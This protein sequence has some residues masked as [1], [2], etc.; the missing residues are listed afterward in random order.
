M[1][2][3]HLKILRAAKAGALP[4]NVDKTTSGFSAEAMRELREAGLIESSFFQSSDGGPEFIDGR[5]TLAG[6]ERLEAELAEV[7]QRKDVAGEQPNKPNDW[8]NQPLGKIAL[9][10]AGGVLLA[11]AMTLLKSCGLV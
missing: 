7:D 2:E 8:H 1:D 4:R 9:T 10:I 6:R 11:L 5:I 3:R